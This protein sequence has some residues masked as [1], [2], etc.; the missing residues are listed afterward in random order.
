MQYQVITLLPY[1]TVLDAAFSVEPHSIQFH[2]KCQSIENTSTIMK[3]L[4]Y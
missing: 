3:L 1:E 4:P 2:I